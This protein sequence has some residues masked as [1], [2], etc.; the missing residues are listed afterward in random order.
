M[1]PVLLTF[2]RIRANWFGHFE[3]VSNREA[4]FLFFEPSCKSWNLPGV[5]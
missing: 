5:G 2:N 4:A 3:G 1:R